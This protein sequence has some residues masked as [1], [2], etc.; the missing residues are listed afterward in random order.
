LAYVNGRILPESEASVSIRDMGLVYGDSVFDTARTF[1]GEIFMLE[2][3]VDRLFESLEYTRIDPGMTKFDFIQATH[4]L[5]ERNLP[6]LREGEDYWVTIRVTGGQQAL[7]GEAPLREGSTIVI[8]CIPIPLRARASFFVKGIEAVVAERRRIAPEALS[9][10]A[11]TSNYLNMILAQK[12]VSAERPG[13]W[14]LMC[15]H[16]GNLAEGAGCN[17]F[18]VRDGVVYTPTTEFILAGIS[19]QVVIE[20]CDELGI[21]LRQQNVSLEQTLSAD[22]AFFTST[23]LCACPVASVN[24]SA[25]DTG[26]PGPVTQRIMDGFADRVGM[27]YV[28]QYRKFRSGNTASTGL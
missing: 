7:D 15:D 14:A 22:E 10:N 23:S 2:A 19:R 5:V 27:D 13:S 28:A 9:P 11:K 18:I 20:L 4:D 24:G 17:F 16:E 3:H 21:P 8:D 25:Y 1:A 26:I 12:E 6:M